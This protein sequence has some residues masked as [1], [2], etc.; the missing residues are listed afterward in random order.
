MKSILF[1]LV[2]PMVGIPVV[3]IVA[4]G[5]LSGIDTEIPAYKEQSVQKE[6]D[7]KIKL[8]EKG[9]PIVEIKNPKFQVL[10]NSSR[11]FM[12]KYFS[13][14]LQFGSL[15]KN[16]DE[17]G[18]YTVR[19]KDWQAGYTT[20]GVFIKSEGQLNFILN[21][22]MGEYCRSHFKANYLMSVKCH[23]KVLSF[24]DDYYGTV[25]YAQ[26]YRIQFYTSGGEVI[27]EINGRGAH[28]LT[29]LGKSLGYPDENF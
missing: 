3:F 23:F 11:K 25:A 9:F 5:L 10:V 13:Y 19:L 1:Y 18:G 12:G 16:R 20:S 21:E 2:A 14:P 15:D 28:S 22:K 8:D 7:S 29:E 26:I 6:I 4:M 27:F 24:F 17:V